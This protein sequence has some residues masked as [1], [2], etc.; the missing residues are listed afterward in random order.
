MEL[1]M[2]DRLWL[3]EWSRLRCDY[4]VSKFVEPDRAI[5]YEDSWQEAVKDIRGNYGDDGIIIFIREADNT[6]R[7]VVDGNV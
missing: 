6:V 4:R 1:K 2:S 3:V 7:Y 5:A